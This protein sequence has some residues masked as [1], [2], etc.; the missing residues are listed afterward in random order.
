MFRSKLTTAAAFTALTIAVLG[1]TPVGQ[2]AGGLVP[3]KHGGATTG[4]KDDAV[5]HGARCPSVPIG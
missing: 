4:L 1:S 3:G 5:A 2:A